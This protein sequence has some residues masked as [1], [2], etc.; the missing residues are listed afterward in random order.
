MRKKD[1]SSCIAFCANA[2]SSYRAHALK[3]LSNLSQP[4][5]QNVLNEADAVT[6]AC[7]LITSQELSTPLS[8]AEE[9]DCVRVICF[10]ADDACNRAKIRK[11]GAFKRLLELAKNTTN[12]SLLKMVTSS[13]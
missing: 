10:L 5:G 6:T 8:E 1:S 9:K 3:I 4:D 7:H 2:D 12:D 11:S 13:I